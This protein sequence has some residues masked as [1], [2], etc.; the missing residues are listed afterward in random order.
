MLPSLSHPKRPLATTSRLNACLTFGLACLLLPAASRA[1]SSVTETFSGPLSSDLELS[2]A[3]SYTFNGV[4]TKT[5][6]ARSYIRTVAT[7]FNTVD[8]SFAATYTVSANSGGAGIAFFGIGQ[9]APDAGFYEEPLISGYMRSFPNNFDSGSSKISINSSSGN[10]DE[11]RPSFGNPGSG[12]HRALITKTGDTITFAIDANSSGGTFVADFSTTLSLSANLSFL[13]AT[14]SR[15]FLGAGGSAATFDSMVI[16]AVPEP[17]SAGLIAGLATLGL[18]TTARRP[19]RA[20][21]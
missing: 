7:N 12:T 13:N 5:A 1:Q 2:L 11:S 19:R 17:A 8:F 16:T 9:G 4:A 20:Q 3:D 21:S 15:L 14:N 10:V 6:V 18:I